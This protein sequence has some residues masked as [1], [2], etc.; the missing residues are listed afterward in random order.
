MLLRAVWRADVQKSQR[1]KL[2][3]N[4]HHNGDEAGAIER[5]LLTFL[6]YSGT[7]ARMKRR[8]QIFVRHPQDSYFITPI[9]IFVY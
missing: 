1:L 2:C 6:P 5:G 7:A 9:K 4:S 8:L 3:H